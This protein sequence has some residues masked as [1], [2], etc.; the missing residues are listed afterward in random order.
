[1]DSF[2]N[3]E[4][5]SG[6]GKEGQALLLPPRL[7]LR[8]TVSSVLWTHVIS[9][10]MPSQDCV[11]RAQSLLF[12]RSFSLWLQKSPC[13]D[14]SLRRV[15]GTRAVLLP[16]TKCPLVFYACSF[17]LSLLPPRQSTTRAGE[18]QPTL[19]LWPTAG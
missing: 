17:P 12:S 7:E 16:R 19:L 2:E 18:K 10:A 8:F 5:E 1:M 4:L 14:R 15:R 13:Q 9:C 6:K 11:W 3:T